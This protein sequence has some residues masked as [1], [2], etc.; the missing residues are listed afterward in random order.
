MT[1]N[2]TRQFNMDI[3]RV[4]LILMVIVLHY[5]NRGMGGALNYAMTGDAR[6]IFVRFSESLCICAVDA[7]LILSGLFST[8]R[9]TSV[10]KK[11][12]GFFIACSFYRTVAYVLHAFFVIHEF[13]IKTFISYM[14]PSNWFVCLFACVMLLCPFIDE[15]LEK[16]TEKKLNE[17]MIVLTIL[18]VVVPTI[19]EVGGDIL[20]VD[21]SGLTTISVWGDADGFGIVSFIYCYIC[22]VYIRKRKELFDKMPR[23][24]YLVIFFIAVFVATFV[25]YLSEKIWSYLDILTVIEALSLTLLF[26]RIKSPSH[27]VGRVISAIG[28]CGLGVFVWHTTPLMLYGFWV[29]FDIGQIS[30][31][32][33]QFMIANMCIAVLSMFAVSVLWVY[34]CRYIVV[35]IKQ[36]MPAKNKKGNV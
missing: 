14:I 21:L 31:G 13:G 3:E 6:E 11:V 27:R 16:L 7:F 19:T 24:Y 26:T 29:R 35:L 17:L 30:E 15:L 4:L 10:Y 9:S 20:G 1:N 32:T 22:G 36:K 8:Y 5:N 23:M 25:S 28:S 2:K 33:L 34:L 18:F 12:L